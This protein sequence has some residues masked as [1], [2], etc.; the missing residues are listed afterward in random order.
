MH[1]LR[2]R[3]VFR[4]GNP[5]V[6]VRKHLLLT[7]SSR[8]I[9]RSGAP[10]LAPNIQYRQSSGEHRDCYTNSHVQCQVT[11]VQPYKILFIII[12]ETNR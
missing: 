6:A 1:A 10:V 12:N 3:P 2:T 5:I 7:C 8:S 11:V 9:S 4:E